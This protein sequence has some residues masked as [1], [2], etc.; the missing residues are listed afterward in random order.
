MIIVG[1]DGAVQSVA[2]SHSNKLLLTG[3]ADNTA[4]LWSVGKGADPVLVLVYI[5][6]LYHLIVLASHRR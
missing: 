4:R 5:V 2:F 3:G 1:H 6:R